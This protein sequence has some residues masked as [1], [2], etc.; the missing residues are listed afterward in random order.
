M[1]HMQKEPTMRQ[2][3]ALTHPASPPPRFS[4][5][6]R[7]LAVLSVSILSCSVTITDGFGHFS[8]T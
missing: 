2:P 5:S 4:A 8:D 1:K 3:K 7:R 6:T